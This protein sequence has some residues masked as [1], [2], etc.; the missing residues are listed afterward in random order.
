MGF[1]SDVLDLLKEIT[2][3]VNAVLCRE[4]RPYGLTF[5]QAEVLMELA[6]ADGMK[7]TEM[8]DRLGMG[9]SN[10]SPLCRRLEERGFLIRRQD[11][12]D[13]RIIHLCLTDR[14]RAM[15]QEIRSGEGSAADDTL[16]LTAEEQESLLNA[17]YLLRDRTR[18]G[19]EAAR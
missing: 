6:D 11:E 14:S 12:V 16:G 1:A 17:L 9:K 18:G 5:V 10:L 8:S 7:I 3:Q 4:Y 15:L 19:E 13:H 2:P